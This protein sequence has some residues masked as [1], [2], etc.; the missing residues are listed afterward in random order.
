MMLFRISYF[1]L[2]L[3]YLPFVVACRYS[4]NDQSTTLQ[5][6]FI[7][8]EQIDSSLVSKLEEQFIEAGLMNLRDL[9]CGILVDLKYSSTDNF[10]QRN[11][12]GH[13]QS[14]Y[15]QPDVARKLQYA[16]SLLK[17]IDSTLTLLVYD[18]ARPL[19]IQQFMWDS[20]DVP[21][22][23]K[24]NFLSDP[25]KGSLHNYGAAVDVTIADLL[26][27]TLDMGT[28]YDFIGELAYPILEEELLQQGDITVQQVENRKILR[29]VMFGAGFTGI[30]SE[31]WH[32]NAC[33]REQ[34]KD[35]YKIIE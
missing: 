19:H 35:W 24:R 32:F 26:G 2:F 20:L 33:T 1:V 30:E 23:E 25:A 8:D 3:V 13:L 11:M 28:P 16:Q 5:Q 27:N 15:L 34:A 31:W 17:E 22:D 7:S 21:M 4:T 6:N 12:Y 18:A 29:T 9:S 10:M 14:A